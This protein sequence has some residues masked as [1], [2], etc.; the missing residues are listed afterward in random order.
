MSCTNCSNSNPLASYSVQYSFQQSPNCQ[1]ENCGTVTNAQC[2]SYTGPNLACSGIVSG[3]SLEKA[4]QTIDTKLCAVSGDYSAYNINCLPGPITT[5]ADFVAAVTSYACTTR[6][7]LTTFTGTT[8][9]V[10]QTTVDN[11]FKALE[12]PGTTCAFAAVTATDTLQQVLD[13]YCTA[14]STLNTA[15]D[16][17][18]ITWN[19]C[20]TVATPPT[21]IKAGLQL[22]ADQI[23]QVKNASSSLP[24]FNNT[25]SCLATPG[26]T[27][28]LVDTI[29]KIK[30]RLCSTDTFNAA[31]IT[32]GC[33]TSATSL[34]G[35]VQNVITKV[36][37]IQQALPTFSA[38]FT[39]TPL[40]A[41]DPCQGVQISLAAGAGTEDHK[42]AINGTDAAPGYLVN[43]LAGVGVSIDDTTTPGK[44]TLTVATQADEKVKAASSDDTAG[45]LYDKVEVN[46]ATGITLSLGYNAATK[47]VSITPNLD[48]DTIWGSL[49]TY[50]ENNPNS[51]LRT[52]FCALVSSCPT[53]C[54]A[55]QNAQVVAAV[56]P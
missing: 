46:S 42:V 45:Y 49:L 28:T 4:L 41:G 6:N 35:A 26:A 7:T 21:T 53:P 43:K 27:D 19:S 31:A 16:I 3:D 17:S 48:F 23:C 39:V 14:F 18:G 5:E 24:T 1:S 15:Q 54:S 37:S 25:G 10:Y 11:R 51:E 50:M 8:F 20:F 52:R 13:K 47:K 55:P 56:A 40:D 30:T 29:E 32:Y 44:V 38:D 22:L 36:S 2:V 9:P 34:Q 33:V 12:V